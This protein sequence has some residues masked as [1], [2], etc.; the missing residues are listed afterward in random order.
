[1]FDTGEAEAM[2][3]DAPG[4]YVEKLRKAFDEAVWRLGSDDWSPG[5]PDVPRVT[6][7][8]EYLTIRGVCDRVIAR[9]LADTMPVHTLD[10]LQQMMHL[11]D[12]DLKEAIGRDE[13]YVNGAQC[14][15]KLMDRRIKAFEQRR[16][17]T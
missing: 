9:E 10:N 15:L 4:A 6:V 8:R 16:N 14:L 11:E 1:M 13:S 12:R 7:D 2:A 17:Q 3:E 5:R